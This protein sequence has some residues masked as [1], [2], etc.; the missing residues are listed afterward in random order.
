[1]FKDANPTYFAV[2][3]DVTPQ[4]SNEMLFFF[5]QYRELFSVFIFLFLLENS[6]SR[7]FIHGHFYLFL[8]WL[9]CSLTHDSVI[10]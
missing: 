10:R 2:I 4:S 9:N 7:P 3:R 8:F 6:I 5:V 1:M